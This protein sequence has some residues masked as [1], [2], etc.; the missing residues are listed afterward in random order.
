MDKE[1]ED[2]LANEFPFMKRGDSYEEQ[3][4]SGGIRDKFGAFGCEVGD[5]WYV[6]LRELCQEITQAY[7]RAG[8]PVVDIVVDRVKEKFGQLRFYYHRV[9]NDPAIHSIDSLAELHKEVAILVR[10][11]REHSTTICESCGAPGVLRR[12]LRWVQS[13]C[14][15]CHAPRKQKIE[16]WRL[17]KEQNDGQKI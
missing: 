2:N 10:Q 7:K 17:R 15:Q 8:L 9:D 14:D 5:G 16:E 13:L 3:E 6:V 12:D 4:K 11:C 1:L